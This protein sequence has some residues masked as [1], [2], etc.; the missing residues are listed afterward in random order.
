MS[1]E[2]HDLRTLEDMEAGK[3]EW[4]DTVIETSSGDIG[5]VVELDTDSILTHRVIFRD[6]RDTWHKADELYVI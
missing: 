3:P 2:S 5:R 6:G 1:F 4:A